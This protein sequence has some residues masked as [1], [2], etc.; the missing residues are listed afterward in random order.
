M[1]AC[2]NSQIGA[3]LNLFWHFTILRSKIN[4][5]G[6]GY[7]EPMWRQI[8]G[9]LLERYELIWRNRLAALLN[10]ELELLW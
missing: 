10:N 4:P 7:S 3:N 1:Y 8:I 9:C 6:I 2:G 5:I